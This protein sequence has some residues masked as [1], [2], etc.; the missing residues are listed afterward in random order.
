MHAKKL[1]RS[2]EA[3]K[4]FLL[5]MKKG[6]FVMRNLILITIFAICS[7]SVAAKEIFSEE[8]CLQLSDDCTP[9][10][11][12]KMMYTNVDFIYSF[13]FSTDENKCGV[14]MAQFAKAEAEL[15]KVHFEFRDNSFFEIT[16]QQTKTTINVRERDC[17]DEMDACKE[18]FSLINQENSLSGATEHTKK[19][20]K[21]ILNRVEKELLDIKK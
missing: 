19:C 15:Y 11:N 18:S 3:E 6:N 1:Y 8:V 17:Q 12:E 4:C 20:M 14:S 7:S 9:G 10:S 21:R 16:T 5:Q 13:Y 2:H